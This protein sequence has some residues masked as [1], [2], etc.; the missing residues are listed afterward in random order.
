MKVVTGNPNQ[1]L[2][3]DWEAAD[4]ALLLRRI[5][6]KGPADESHVYNW[7]KNLEAAAGVSDA[8]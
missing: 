1:V 8:R 3:E 2:L 7:V 6:A 5:P 4:L